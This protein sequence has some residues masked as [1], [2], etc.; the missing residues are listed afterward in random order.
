MDL[1]EWMTVLNNPDQIPDLDDKIKECEYFLELAT[2]EADINKFRWLSS[3]F[4]SAAYSFF[5]IKA[6]EL[7]HMFEDRREAG[8]TCED[9]GKLEILHRYVKSEKNKRTKGRIDTRAVVELAK[10]FREIR[11]KNT[12]EAP[13]FIRE[14]EVGE[15]ELNEFLSRRDVKVLQFFRDVLILLNGVKAELDNCRLNG[16]RPLR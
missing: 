5:E 13:L 14:I 4:L 15:P 11:R 10:E 9:E 8:E 2:K 3:A 12:H 6:V 16:L 1:T 7:W